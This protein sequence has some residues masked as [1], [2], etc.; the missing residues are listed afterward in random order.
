MTRPT[1]APHLLAALAAALLPLV[2]SPPAAAQ[3]ER[4]ATQL[5]YNNGLDAAK[6]GDWDKAYE[7]FSAAWRVRQ[8]PQI[9]LN[10]GRA[11]LKTARHGEAAEYLAF[12]LRE[13]KDQVE[14]QDRALVQELLIEAKQKV[15]TLIIKVNRAGA[16]VV[17]DGNVV[18]Q[19]PLARDLYLDPGSHTVEARLGKERAAP[20]TVDLSAGQSRQLGLSFEKTSDAA[21]LPSGAEEAAAPERDAGGP[22]KAILIAG[23]IVS[24]AGILAGI[25]LTIGAATAEG[26]DTGAGASGNDGLWA[27]AAAG[28]VV[29]TLA[30]GATLLYYLVT[31]SNTSPPKQTARVVPVATPEGGGLWLTGSW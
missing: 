26:E 18:G 31:S 27:G 25:G 12:F 19:A 29:G 6:Q 16:E 28:Y 15:A 3:A 9:A 21:P 7:A 13:T 10:L 24:G 14:N 23:G 17:V 22:Q 2:L 1:S 4:D 30:G 5:L 11:A 8:H 20:I